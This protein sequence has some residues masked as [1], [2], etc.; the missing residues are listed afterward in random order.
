MQNQLHMSFNLKIKWEKSNW[1]AVQCRE[2]KSLG[3]HDDKPQ[4]CKRLL[5]RE[6]ECCKLFFMSMGRGHAIMGLNWSK[7][8][9]KYQLH[10]DIAN[11]ALEPAAEGGYIPAIIEGFKTRIKPHN[12]NQSAVMSPQPGQCWCLAAE[13]QQP[14]GFTL[15][16]PGT[17]FISATA[18]TLRTLCSKNKQPLCFRISSYKQLIT[19]QKHSVT[20]DCCPR[21]IFAS[22]IPLDL[23]LRSQKTPA[24]YPQKAGT[25]AGH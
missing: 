12:L 4:I 6:K 1:K 18:N 25:S 7:I 15:T 11:Y 3:K 22:L 23:I 13:P 5:Q 17:Q 10:N 24:N 19:A 8:F 2:Q 9:K 14:T 16:C 20:R 21:F